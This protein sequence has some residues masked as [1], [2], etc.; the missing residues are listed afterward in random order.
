MAEKL[1]QW[2][3]NR[4]RRGAYSRYPWETWLDGNIWK[5][6]KGEDFFADTKSMRMMVYKQAKDRNARCNTTVLDES[7]IDIQAVMENNNV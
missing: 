3:N 6:T 1:D 4:V 2:P 7:T 5:L